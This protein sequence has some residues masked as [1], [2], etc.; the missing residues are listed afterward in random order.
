MYIYIYI[1]VYIYL[2]IYI[3]IYIFYIYTA[4][5]YALSNFNTVEMFS[6]EIKDFK[7]FFR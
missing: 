6:C 1:Y 5:K 4:L 3:Y 2:Y 7:P